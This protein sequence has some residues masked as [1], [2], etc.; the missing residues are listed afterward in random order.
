MSKQT[1]QPLPKKTT[2]LSQHRHVF[3]S[4]KRFM[5]D[6]TD[7]LD[8]PFCKATIKAKFG[9][10]VK[11]RKKS[12]FVLSLDWVRFN[13][14]IFGILSNKCNTNERIQEKNVRNY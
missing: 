6:L 2:S 9:C 11:N 14:S 3:K 5:S 7:I 12:S 13:L 1:P 10:L 8:C 4:S